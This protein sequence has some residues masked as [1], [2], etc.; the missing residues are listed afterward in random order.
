MIK[1]MLS[2]IF[3][4]AGYR[5]IRIGRERERLM[6][7]FS[8]EGALFRAS[9][10]DIKISSVIDVGASDGRWSRM[11]R[12]YFPN[13]DYLLIEAQ[14]KHEP[15]L[16]E[17]CRKND[18]ASFVLCAAGDRD[19]ELNFDSTALFGGLASEKP[20][21]DNNIVVKSFRL[22]TLI[23][24][25][26]L[27]SPYFIKLDTHGFEIPILNGA[28]NILKNTNMLLIESYNFKISENSLRFYELCSFL[29]KK[30]FLPIDLADLTRRKK[31]NSFW[32]VDILFI[33][34]DNSVFSSNTYN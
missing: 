3:S 13:A 29:E 4:I 24:N 20:F 6:S 14:A 5:I 17:Y 7:E 19:G 34:K 1:K 32:Q 18:N 9:G 27:S 21:K 31:D 2:R 28:E 30:G 11:C 10:M 33:K 25:N 16:I 22:D 23:E 15:G 8:Q 12:N 26:N